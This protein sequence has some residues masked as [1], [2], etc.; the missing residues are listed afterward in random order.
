MS[1]LAGILTWKRAKSVGNCPVARCRAIAPLRLGLLAFLLIVLAPGAALAEGTVTV[2]PSSVL[3][4]QSVTVRG[5]GWAPN[6]QI[7]VSFTDPN[8]NVLPLGVILADARGDFQKT[9]TVPD[10]VPPGIY[11]ID[12]NGQGGSVTVKVTIVAPTATPPP[13]TPT[14]G[15]PIGPRSPTATRRPDQATDTPTALPTETPTPSPTATPTRTPTPTDTPTPTATDTATP[16]A[17]P[18]PT[19]TPTLPQRVVEAGQ[20]AGPTLLLLLLVPIAVAGGYFAGRR[21]G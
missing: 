6:D 11:A 8:G 19:N 5:A 3:P 13:P 7:L 20:G 14:L 18:T 21:R 10:T 16:T 4:G 17:T 2:S 15:P 1:M 9:I 12:G